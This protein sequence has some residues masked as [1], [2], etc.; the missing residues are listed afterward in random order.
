M[1]PA[2][3]A[4]WSLSLAHGMIL[5]PVPTARQ[6]PKASPAK[7]NED[8]ELIFIIVVNRAGQTES[9]IAAMA[10]IKFPDPGAQSFRQPA[11]D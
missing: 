3:G 1:R 5:L 10:A 4:N 7:I 9:S 6:L 11:G 2:I 8:A